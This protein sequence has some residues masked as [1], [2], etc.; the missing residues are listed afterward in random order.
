MAPTKNTSEVTKVGEEVL[1]LVIPYIHNVED[2]N[3]VSLVSRKVCEIDGITRK[4][5]TVHTLLYT[6][7]AS[8][9]KRFPFIE[10][11]TLKGTPSR[12]NDDYAVRITPWIQQLALKF[13]CL[14]E[15]HIH[16]L[17]VHDNDLE[18]LARTRGKD[19]RSL[20]IKWCKGFSTDGLRHVSNYCNQLRTLSLV[21]CH[22]VKDGIWFHQL[23]LNSTVLE[24]LHVM[25]IDISDYSEDL[26]LLA[27]NCCNSL[28]SLKIGKCYL[29]KLGDA[30]RYAA[31]L[32]HFGGDICNEESQLVGF[33]FPPNMRSLITGDLPVTRYSIVLPFLIQIRKLKLESVDFPFDR[34]KKCQCLLFKRCPNLEVLYTEDVCGDRGLQVISKFCKKL[35]KLTYK[36][37][38]THV[39]LVVVAKGCTNLESLKVRL[40]DISNE[41]LECLG[42][43]LKNLR[44][45]R[46][47]LDRKYRTTDLPL[48]NGIR[49]MLMGCSKLERL[50]I[51]LSLSHWHGGLTDVGSLT[52]V[53]LE[54]IVKYGANLRSLSLTLIGNSNAGLVK[55]T[56]GCPR[57]R[58]LKLWY[59]PFSKQAVASSVFILPSLRY[60]WAQS[61]DFTT[62]VLARPDF[63]L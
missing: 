50:D 59:C 41:A 44:E 24:R 60:V 32:E 27:K 2:R 56:E 30:F 7:P 5:L 47:Y 3:S 48:D 54:Y 55:L 22:L 40:E 53:G 58:K 18:K 52:N 9:S 61:R 25:R 20:K 17:V 10:S 21:N 45:F 26:T 34:D 37:V 29:S 51:R 1:D 19:L 16:S 8:L 28:I 62:L 12:F 39:G 6:K 57:L 13:R 49:A 42:A 31:R 14:K 46:M 36:R 11:L 35:R 38:A 63:E 4:R 23:A 33:Q 15:L 43:H